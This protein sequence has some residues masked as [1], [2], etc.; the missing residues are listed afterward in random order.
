[1]SVRADRAHG[2]LHFGAA[3]CDHCAFYKVE[4]TGEGMLRGRIKCGWKCKREVSTDI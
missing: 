2:C 1:M 3:Q 4:S